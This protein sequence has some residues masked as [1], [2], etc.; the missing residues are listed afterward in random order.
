MSFEN[1]ISMRILYPQPVSC[2]WCS[3]FKT[4][5][6]FLYTTPP[7]WWTIPFSKTQ[8]DHLFHL[9]LVSHVH[10]VVLSAQSLCRRKKRK[11]SG[12]FVFDVKTLFNNTGPYTSKERLYILQKEYFEPPKAADDIVVMVNASYSFEYLWLDAIF[13]NLA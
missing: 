3:W 8:K 10:S 2:L 5:S 13:H 6:N 1:L 7:R 11:A 9:L 4:M 12:S